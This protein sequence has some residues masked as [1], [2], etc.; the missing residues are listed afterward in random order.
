M[1]T[2]YVPT[3]KDLLAA[4]AEVTLR[5][6]H[7]NHILRMTIKT[8]A[9]LTPAEAFDATKYDGAR[10]LRDTIKKLAKKKLGTCEEQLKLSAMMTRAERLTGKRNDLTHGLWAQELDGDPGVMG[11]PGEITP[12]PSAEELRQLADQLWTLTKE[13]NSARLEGFL[14]SALEA[15]SG[16][17]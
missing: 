7:L 3:D 4:L 1:L 13:L 12:L 14:K 17:Q 5:N 2:F 10:Q 16:T 11:A 6:E 15:R 8:L 9:G